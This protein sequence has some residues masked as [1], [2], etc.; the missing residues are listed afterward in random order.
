MDSQEEKKNQRI[1]AAVSVGIHGL[2]LLLFLFVF[3]WKAPDPPLPE[4]GIE[5]NFGIGSPGSGIQPVTTPVESET[6]EESQLEEPIDNPIPTDI[7]QHPHESSETV[8]DETEMESESSLEEMEVRDVESPDVR[9][10]APE[11]TEPN[12]AENEKSGSQITETSESSVQ[13]DVT[14]DGPELSVQPKQQNQGD[15]IETLGD[16]GDPKGKLDARALY[17]KP[18]GGDGASLQLAGWIWDFLP[19]PDDQSQENGRI[20][21]EIVIDE[22]G[23]LIVVRTIEKTVSPQVEKIYKSEVEKLTFSTTSDNTIPAPRSTGTITFI[24]RSR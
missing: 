21:F 11:K 24:I 23:E 15:E 14:D 1:G 2:V 5:L 18:G 16:S 6:I 20:V 4:Y 12:I 9:Q 17:G 22:Q 19:K 7:E 3:A 10:P 13:V 8:V